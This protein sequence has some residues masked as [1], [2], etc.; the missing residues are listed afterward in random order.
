MSSTAMTVLGAVAMAITAALGFGDL[1]AVFGEWEPTARFCLT[2]SGGALSFA[3]GKS[4][5]GNDY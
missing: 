2:V 3:L 5:P 4:N 1:P